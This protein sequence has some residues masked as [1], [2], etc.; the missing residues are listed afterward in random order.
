MAV[1][2]LEAGLVANQYRQAIASAKA[3][4]RSDVEALSGLLD[5][6]KRAFEA[7]AWRGGAS[8]E[9]YGQLVELR[10]DAQNAA[11]QAQNEFDYGL[12]AQAPMVPADSWQARWFWER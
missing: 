2:P 8:D 3:R 7:G 5:A 6:A 11:A 12:R 1:D 10:K 4:S 9:R